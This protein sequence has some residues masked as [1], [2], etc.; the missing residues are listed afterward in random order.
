MLCFEIQEGEIS[1]TRSAH[2]DIQRIFQT[3]AQ[4]TMDNVL[5]KDMATLI[6]LNKVL[7]EQAYEH[8]FTNFQ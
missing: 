4:Q 5:R 3:R 7:L 6:F 8:C 1:D 2:K